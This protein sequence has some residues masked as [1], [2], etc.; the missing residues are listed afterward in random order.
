MRGW[1]LRNEGEVQQLISI[2][3]LSRVNIFELRGM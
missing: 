1:M 2:D 3:W